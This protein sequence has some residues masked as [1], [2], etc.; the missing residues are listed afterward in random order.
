MVKVMLGLEQ[1]RVVLAELIRVGCWAWACMAEPG[2]MRDSLRTS[3]KQ[4]FTGATPAGFAP[5][6]PTT[7]E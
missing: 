3:P 2:S 5:V 1:F 4:G 7:L 6:K